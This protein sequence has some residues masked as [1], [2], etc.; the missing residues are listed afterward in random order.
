MTHGFAHQHVASPEV[1][2]FCWYRVRWSFDRWT[3]VRFDSQGELELLSE[4][5]RQTLSLSLSLSQSLS[6]ALSSQALSHRMQLRTISMALR[7]KR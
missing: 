2:F 6:H 3:L 5:G 7:L 4:R 1:F